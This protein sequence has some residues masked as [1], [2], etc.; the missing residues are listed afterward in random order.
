MFGRHKKVKKGI[1]TVL[2][3]SGAKNLTRAVLVGLLTGG[4]YKIFSASKKGAPHKA[5]GSGAYGAVA[6]AKAFKGA[7][8]PLSKQ[9]I[10]ERYGK[11]EVEYYR[12]QPKKISDLL[13]NI[14][15]ET[16]NSTVDVEHAFREY[17]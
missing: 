9:E 10:M 3:L 6:I 16:F 7:D 5:M 15:D 13:A 12:G 17:S 11:K 14:P 4:L 8:F 2:L 1:F